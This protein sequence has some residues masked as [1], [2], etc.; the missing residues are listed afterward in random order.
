MHRLE[1]TGNT[2]EELYFNCIK[3]LSIM[4]KGAGTQPMPANEPVVETA[5]IVEETAVEQPAPVA[6]ETAPIAEVIPP[7]KR[8]PKP[9]VKTEALNDDIS[10]LGGAPKKELTLDGDIKPRLQAISAACTKRGMS[11]P[12]TVAYIQKLYAPFG[13][14]K[15]PQL[16]PE[17]FEEFMEASEAYLDGTAE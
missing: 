11:M 13:I 14:A 10:D 16:K 12:D 5:V 1:I 17:Q 2:P 15:A 7:K 4:L 9:R 6:E 8:G 3:T